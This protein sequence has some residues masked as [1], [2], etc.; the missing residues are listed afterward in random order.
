MSTIA[1]TNVKHPSAVD[2]AIVLDADGDVT[3]AGVHD[4]SAATVTGAPQG[5]VHIAT[6][7]FSAVS[8]V[9]LNGVFTSAYE[10]YKIIINGTASTN[11]DFLYRLRNSGVDASGANYS[12]QRLVVD[13][14]SVSATRATGATSGEITSIL[15]TQT[16]MEV[17]IY[18]PQLSVPTRFVTQSGDSLSSNPR[19]NYNVS[20]HSLSSGYD[21]VTMFPS[22]GNITGTIR[23]YGYANS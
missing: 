4:F 9:S 3:Y 18:S 21:G 6:Q 5:L 17:E 12:T 19:V 8:S 13:N 7:S 22:T 11:I 10:N 14:T 20:L 15:T 2:P 23:V 16:G 1:V